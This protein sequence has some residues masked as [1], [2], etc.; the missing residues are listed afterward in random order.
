MSGQT[1]SGVSFEGT[2]RVLDFGGVLTHNRHIQSGR[3]IVSSC[4][5]CTEG[6]EGA[7]EAVP[8]VVPEAA[9]AEGDGD[10]EK[11][12]APPPSGGWPN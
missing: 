4:G 8:Q 9:L 12:G 1:D 3:K 6:L 7:L 11:E 2:D 5:V 10:D